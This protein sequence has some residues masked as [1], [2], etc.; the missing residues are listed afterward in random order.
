MNSFWANVYDAV[1]DRRY[2]ML[3]FCTFFAVLALVVMSVI[4]EQAIQANGWEDAWKT[5]VMPSLIG[6][7]VIAVGISWQMARKARKRRRQRLEWAALSRDEM[8]K[9][10]SKLRA[11]KLK[12]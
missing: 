2:G 9:A 4:T 1:K 12:L 3:F 11:S 10:R 5:Y 6:I 8:D 7:G